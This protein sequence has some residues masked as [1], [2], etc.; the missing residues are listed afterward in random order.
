MFKNR[1]KSKRKLDE[2]RIPLQLNYYDDGTLFIPKNVETSL[3]KSIKENKLSNLIFKTE[4]LLGRDLDFLI[5]PT[6][7][8]GISVWTACAS[9]SQEPSHVLRA[10]GLSD[11][12]ARASIRFGLGR[13]NTEVE[14]DYVVE[15][16]SSLVGRLREPVPVFN[17]RDDDRDLP[18]KW[19]KGSSSEV[20]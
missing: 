12:R 20:D 19:Y 13:F 8:L 9:N 5:E 4:N 18:S 16:L 2:S 1:F 7:E 17:L 14:V 11:A 15:K 10:L 6:F 3:L